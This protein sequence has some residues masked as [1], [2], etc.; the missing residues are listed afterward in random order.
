MGNI[1]INESAT[2]H[3][4]SDFSD[5]N[6]ISIASSDQRARQELDHQLGLIRSVALIISGATLSSFFLFAV[7]LFILPGNLA[8]PALMIMSCIGI[9]FQLASFF[10]AKPGAGSRSI[11]RAGNLSLIGVFIGMIVC[12]ILLGGGGPIPAAYLLIPILTGI[13]GLSLRE[14]ILNNCR[15]LGTMA[16]LYILEKILKLYQPPIELT[17]YPG[18]VLA[19]WLMLIV[20][21]TLCIGIFAYRL[22]KAKTSLE[23][24]T[25]KLAQVLLALN[26]TTEFSAT[27][28]QELSGVTT[29]LNATSH[30]Q[31][32][33]SQEQVAAITQITGS[34]EEL[35]ENASQ[36]ADR[37][38]AVVQY[39]NQM[40]AISTNV[41]KV[42]ET[43]QTSALQGKEA[44]A[45]SNENVER[46]RH[47]IELLAQRLLQLTEQ[48]KKLGAIVVLHEEIAN[49][50]HLLSLN[51]SI[52]AAGSAG[53]TD[54]GHDSRTS[55]GQR[56]GVI[57]Q[58]VKSLADRSRESTEEIRAMINQMQ[59]SVA[60]AV[61]VAEEAR[62]E[63]FATLA[64][65][66][67]AGEV[68]QR[69]NQVVGE[70]A[71][72][73]DQILDS[74][75]VILVQGEEI[76]LATQQ[77]RSA[78]RQILATMHGLAHASK[79]SAGAVL[80]LSETAFRVDQRVYELNRVL[81]QVEHFKVSTT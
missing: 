34:L 13:L 78:N 6:R 79:E 43:A 38:A 26:S 40:V 37:T 8:P 33:G 14:L 19:V 30:Q 74:A 39:V 66:Q 15:S 5:N 80:Q 54:K 2:E 12:Q 7:L 27:L 22:N 58:Q 4:A 21:I 42:S 53:T 35:S 20:L 41:K 28:S 57:A 1:R 51:A 52:E 67:Q 18:I 55:S 49:E 70:S 62:K 60:A 63:T 73:A 61:L 50:T 59:G 81:S 31:A 44:L 69:L 64:R 32:S 77:Q 36:I 47:R 24:Q 3:P 29:E 46:V 76:S 16:L 17:N 23:N 25:E 56:F 11:R 71:K 65:S 10:V 48:H 75:H 72:Q 45:H 68:I 9:L